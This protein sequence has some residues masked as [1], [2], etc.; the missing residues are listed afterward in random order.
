MTKPEASV[1]QNRAPRR[2]TGGVA[3]QRTRGGAALPIGDR[4]AR[5][6]EWEALVAM[7]PADLEQTARSDQA[8]QRWRGISSA[9]VLLRAVLLY[10]LSDWSLQSVAAHLAAIVLADLSAVALRGRLLKLVDWL[11]HLVL[12][13][14]RGNRAS[15]L[16]QPVRVR[17][18]DATTASRP[19]S[20]G[21][22][23]RIHLSCDVGAG[24]IVGVEVTDAHGGESL[25]RHPTAPDEISVAD[26]GHAH[27]RGLGALLRAQGRLIVRMNAQNLPLARTDG[28]PL[29][30]G[31]WLRTV[32]PT[33]AAELPVQVATP[34]GL[35]PL[36]LIARRLAPAAAEAARRRLRESA[37][38]KGHTP[39]A[40]GLEAAGFV[41]LVSNLPAD[42]WDAET[43]LALYRFRWRMELLFKRLKGILTLDR[44]AVKNPALAQVVLLSKLLGALLAERASHTVA[45]FPRDWFDSLQR[46]VSL[47]RW[48]VHWADAVW[49]AVHGPLPWHARGSALPRLRRYLCDPPRKRVQQAAGARAMLRTRATPDPALP[50]PSACA[51][52]LP[53]LA[54]A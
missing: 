26:R 8:V 23:W 7:I 50:V 35:F 53:L 6:P 19:G 24:R 28:T 14:A 47:W 22:D 4:L 2:A 5:D 40:L 37:R 29:D 39:T 44:L 21:T 9:S 15:Y 33:A 1:C 51:H 52:R 25:A 12:L 3:V 16:S 38:K 31:P 36:R 48:L 54:Y 49:T 10:A 27:R 41:L 43:L 34:D 18:I 42:A 17:L 46:P 45:V 11:G 30:R 32:P 13:C 20:T